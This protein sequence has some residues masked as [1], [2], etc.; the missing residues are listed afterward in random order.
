MNVEVLLLHPAV[1]FI[2]GALLMPFV[3]NIRLQQTFC[4]VI[5]I[6]AF[7][8]IYNLPASAPTVC[9]LGLQLH[10]L[11]VDTLSFLFLHVFCLMA[12]I[13]ALYSL[14]VREPDHHCAAF[15][16]VAGSLGVVL[17]GDYLTLFVCWELMAIASTLLIVQRRTRESL[18]AGF[19]YLLIHVAGGLS[20]FAGI[21]IKYAHSGSLSFVPIAP[22]AAGPADILI[23]I[24]FM[25]NAAVPPLHAWLADAY[26]EATVTGAVY[27]CAFTTKTAVYALCRAFSGFEVLTLLG[28]G[29]A[30]F[31][32]CFAIVENNIRR[33]LAYHIISQVGYM[34]CGIG[35]GTDMAVNGA[36]SHAYAHIIY[37]A[38]LFMGAGCVLEMTGKQKLTELGGLYRY[39]PYSFLFTVIGGISISGFPLTSG[40]V[41]KSMV[42]VAAAEVH[43]AVIFMI[44]MLASIGT[45]LSV[46]IKLPYF[47]WFGKPAEVPARE[48]PWNMR[49]AMTLAAVICL[50]IGCYP[51]LLY[52]MLPHPVLYQ[53]YTM[54]HLSEALQLLGFTGLG[55]Y[56]LAKKLAPRD[57]IHLDFDWLYRRLARL[58]MRLCRNP[59]QGIDTALGELSHRAGLQHLMAAARFCAGFDLQRLDRYIDGAARQVLVCGERV[60]TLHTGN[61]QHYIGAALMLLFLLLVLGVFS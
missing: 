4:V 39:M 34:V 8:M 9:Y 24:G 48:A 52:R 33:I 11:R 15:L 2:V 17:S 25:L 14:H 26:P 40:F 42:T 5:P 1:P 61:I 7:V 6:A 16:Y 3:R 19:R 28:A 20:L 45:F 41:S 60:R 22:A 21:M 53:P 43:R 29:M 51:Q 46:G 18:A 27:L 32:V 10:V 36:C 38:L 30:L 54:T 37:K 56:L 47:V 59:L 50:G 35:I 13:G 12:L 49:C 55:F 58:F 31:G 57:V 23:M 44:L